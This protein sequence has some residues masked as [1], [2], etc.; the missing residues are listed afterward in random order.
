MNIL[1]QSYQETAMKYLA[2]SLALRKSIALEH[3]DEQ[4]PEYIR[5]MDAPLSPKIHGLSIKEQLENY[6]LPEF[7]YRLSCSKSMG[8]V[9]AR[10]FRKSAEI[11]SID[12]EL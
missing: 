12:Y 4:F 3:F 1:I 2:W 10:A 7:Y 5:Q 11:N 6:A 9:F 8:A